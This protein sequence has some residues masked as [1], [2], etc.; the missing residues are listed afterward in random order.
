[1]GPQ[2]GQFGPGAA[3]Y[4]AMGGTMAG[5]SGAMVPGMGMMGRDPRGLGAK[6]ND[7]IM[8][9]NEAGSSVLTPAVEVAPQPKYGKE[10]R[11]VFSLLFLRVY[12]IYWCY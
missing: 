9:G 10:I 12:L 3:G 11:M 2:M 6:Q 5:L 8:Q 4:G 7:L 1:M